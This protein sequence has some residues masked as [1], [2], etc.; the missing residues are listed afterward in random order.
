MSRRRPP[1]PVRE[2]VAALTSAGHAADVDL[3]GGHYK[4]S[5]TA[6]GR[7]H[8]LVLSRSPSDRRAQA[9]SRSLLRRLLEK[10]H[11]S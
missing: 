10:G 8:L 6:A 11:S 4:I 9:N 3:A 7:R 5:W 1:V 2:A